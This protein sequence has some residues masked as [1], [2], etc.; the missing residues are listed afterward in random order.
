MPTPLL[1]TSS[2][3]R[4]PMR[5]AGWVSSSSAAARSSSAAGMGREG[6][7][8]RRGCPPPPRLGTRTGGRPG[9]TVLAEL[10]QV[11]LGQAQL[12]LLRRLLHLLLRRFPPPPPPQRRAAGTGVSTAPAPP[13][14]PPPAQPLLLRLGVAG[15]LLVDGPSGRRPR[16]PLGTRDLRD[17]PG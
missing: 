15:H 12:L 7:A 6:R 16:P 9:L 4:S 14:A 17:A 1:T 8:Q 5:S 3:S 11:Q 10:L 2:F 13:P